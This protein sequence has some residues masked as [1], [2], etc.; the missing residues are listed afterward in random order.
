[1]F[2][3]VEAGQ[4]KRVEAIL[5]G[6]I[7]ESCLQELCGQDARGKQRSACI[8]VVCMVP[9]GDEGWDFTSVTPVVSRDISLSGLSILH[10]EPVEGPILLEAP[11]VTGSRFV[12][13]EVQHCRDLGH[14]YF[15]IGLSAKEV[16]N[17]EAIDR[18]RIERRLAEFAEEAAATTIV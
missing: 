1:M 11:S 4:R 2:D 13:C 12:R 9:E 8:Q 14:G 5:A 10:R 3:F 7:N 6:R 15:H 17:I 16:V 18:N